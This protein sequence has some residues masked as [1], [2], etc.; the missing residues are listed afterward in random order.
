MSLRLRTI[1][2]PIRAALLVVLFTGAVLCGC[3]SADEYQ[4]DETA[5]QPAPPVRHELKFTGSPEEVT[6]AREMAEALEAARLRYDLADTVGAELTIDSLIIVAEAALD[7]LPL[8]HKLVDFLMVY[9]ADAYGGLQRWFTAQGEP[10]AVADL[11]RRYNAL[12]AR[13]QARRDSAAANAP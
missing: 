13:L 2:R 3:K 9:V 1:S 8:E 10:N 11:N 4:R 5:E 7:T 6:W 12:A